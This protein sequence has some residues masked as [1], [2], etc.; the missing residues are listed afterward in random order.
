ME[1]CKK[2]D[3]Y[4]LPTLRFKVRRVSRRDSSL[5]VGESRAETC[6]LKRSSALRDDLVYCTQSPL[7]LFPFEIAGAVSCEQVPLSIARSCA[8]EKVRYLAG[9][10]RKYSVE[11]THLARARAI[12]RRVVR[13]T[14]H[15]ATR[16][17]TCERTRRRDPRLRMC[18]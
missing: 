17:S 7:R 15:P 9:R 8:T 6:I 2:E 4:I 18:T 16:E 13:E 5:V 10:L 1:M 3:N 12:R 11:G 14:R